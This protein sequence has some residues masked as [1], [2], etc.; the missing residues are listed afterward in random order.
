MLNL[1]T[2][3]S[4]ISLYIYNHTEGVQTN[5]N[6]QMKP[7]II[8]PSNGP[9]FWTASAMQL[10]DSWKPGSTLLVSLALKLSFTVENHQPRWS[11]GP[12]STDQILKWVQYISI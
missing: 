12:E 11:S 4:R 1:T 3:S 2:A 10:R 6:K 7:I 8:L 9:C 5:T